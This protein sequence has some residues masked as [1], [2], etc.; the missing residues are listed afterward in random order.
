MGGVS[1]PPS[2]LLGASLIGILP[3]TEVGDNVLDDLGNGVFSVAGV[4][5]FRGPLGV[6]TYTFWLQEGPMDTVYTFDF[7]VIEVPE[8]TTLTRVGILASGAIFVTSVRRG[9]DR[10]HP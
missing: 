6:G 7:Q 4:P 10:V 1:G 2:D 3:G 5:T 9:K 8:P